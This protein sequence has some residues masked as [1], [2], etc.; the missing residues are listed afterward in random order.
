MKLLYI[1]P[2]M[3]GLCACDKKIIYSTTDKLDCGSTENSVKVK[4][5]SIYKDYA[6]VYRDSKKFKFNLVD[7][8]YGLGSESFV[9]TNSKAANI[10]GENADLVAFTDSFGQNIG[11]IYNR[12]QCWFDG[13]SYNPKYTT[14]LQSKTKYVGE[15]LVNQIF[16]FIDVK[17]VSDI[18]FDVDGIE[19]RDFEMNAQAKCGVYNA[20]YKVNG[21]NGWLQLLDD[22]KPCE[23]AKLKDGEWM[24]SFPYGTVKGE[25]LCSAKDGDKQSFKYDETKEALWA[26]YGYTLETVPGEKKYCWCKVNGLYNSATDVNS[27]FSL[28]LNDKWVF[29]ISE[30]YENA[31]GER[32]AG[33]CATAALWYRDFRRA[34]YIG[35]DSPLIIDIA[36]PHEENDSSEELV[37]EENSL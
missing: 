23:T 37:Q 11:F 30:K 29:V 20:I 25:S 31:C 9:G 27:R 17:S 13:E 2:V 34:S 15:E 33:Y 4:K 14:K 10:Y 35:F 36:S 28:G 26:S 7:R 18:P 32:C 19:A 1:I 24:V 16:G 22:T 6:V 12:Q 8:V 5:I 3:L 21:N